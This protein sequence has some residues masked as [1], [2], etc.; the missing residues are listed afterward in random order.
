MTPAPQT[1]SFS[2]LSSWDTC[3]HAWKRN[4][5]E[6]DRGEDNFFNT[7]GTLGHSVLEKVD[8]KEITPQQAFQEW[9]SRYY[10][11]V[12]PHTEEWMDGWKFK[13]DKFFVNFKG[14]RTEAVWIEEHFT[15]EM[16]GF[17][18]QGYVDRLGRTSSGDLI[19]TD[20]KCSKPYEGEKL[21]EKA[22]QLYLY[23][24]A[25][26]RAFGKWPSKMVFMHFKD[27]VPV[28]VPFRYDDM[29]EAVMW[30]DRTVKDIETYSGDYPM[31]DNGYFCEAVCGFRNTCEKRFS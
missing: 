22:R 2:R 31:Q 26:N 3:K 6:G 17:L 21:K 13:A 24:I 1:Y 28:T 10:D 15:I 20:Y 9:V 16:D 11:E 5:I 30:A 25:V 12:V 8:R 7:F 27:N 19:L 14:W 29:L 23:S 4:Y 18:F